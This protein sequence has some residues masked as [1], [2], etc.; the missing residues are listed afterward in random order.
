M[1]KNL[2]LSALSVDDIVEEYKLLH[3]RHQQLKDQSDKDAQRIY[4]LKRSLD[5]ALA[6]E[7][8]LTQELEQLSSQPVAS[9]SGGDMQ[10]LEERVYQRPRKPSRLN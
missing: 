2:D 6:A 7:S 1:F 5:T 9:N 10:E 8:Y 4:E 3:D